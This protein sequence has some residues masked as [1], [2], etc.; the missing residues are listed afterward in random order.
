LVKLATWGC[1]GGSLGRK[2]SVMTRQQS[3]VKRK[4]GCG[5]REQKPTKK[6]IK[7]G[8]EEK[9]HKTTKKHNI[10]VTFCLGL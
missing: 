8:P 6:Q 1:P 3:S 4:R 9:K 5:A 10:E 2:S 7:K